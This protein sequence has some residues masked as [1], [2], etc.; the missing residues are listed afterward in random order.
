MA[1]PAETHAAHHGAHHHDEPGWVR[2]YLFSTDHKI[3]AM[4]YMFTGMALA[5]IGGFFAY[6]FRMQMAFPG[7]EVPF[8]GLVTPNRYN[9]LI[10]NHGAIMIFWVAMPVLIAA[11]GNFLIPLMIGCDDM[12]F[13]R[14]NRLSY[15][16]FFLSAVVLR[17]LVLRARAAPSAAPGPST[18]RSRRKRE[19]NLTPLGLEPLPGGGG[20][21]VRRLPA[22]RHQLHHHRD[23]L[24]R[25]GHEAL[26]HAD[27]G[28]DD[29]HRE[30][31]VHGLGRSADRGRHDAVH[32]PAG[33]HGLLRSGPRRR[34]DA[35]A[36]PVLVLR[37]PGGLRGAAAGARHRGRDHHG[38]L[39]QEAVRLQDGA[40]HRRSAPA[41]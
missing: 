8:Y 7:M 25:A 3:I 23:E 20:A 24:P 39:A 36:A 6:V 41:C 11:F 29:R 12:V 38:V 13:P 2:K 18:R 4:Q 16:I 32:G 21:R 35:L 10:T 40:L 30:H 19:Y 26:R 27:R 22:R 34:P 28:L 9:V 17:R 14:I 1:H 33:R 31:P 5:L 15:Q 37:A